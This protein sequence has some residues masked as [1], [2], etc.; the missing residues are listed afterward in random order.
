[1]QSCFS[2]YGNH[3]Q[4]TYCRVKDQIKENLPN[5][6]GYIRHHAYQKSIC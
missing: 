1:M 5:I 4:L 2:A 3:L 6:H